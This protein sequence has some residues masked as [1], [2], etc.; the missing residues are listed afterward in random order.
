[1]QKFFLQK[2]LLKLQKK[3]RELL[4]QQAAE[5]KNGAKHR[6]LE[7]FNDALLDSPADLIKV[8]LKIWGDPF[9]LNDS[10]AGNYTAEQT[11]FINITKDGSADFSK[12]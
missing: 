11:E 1:M 3:Q 8:D 12:F 5:V 6:L 7:I 4:H 9:W 2:V 10:G